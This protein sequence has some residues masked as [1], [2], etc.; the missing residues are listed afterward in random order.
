MKPIIGVVA[1]SYTDLTRSWYPNTQGVFHEHLDAVMASGAVPVVLPITDDGAI[2]SQLYAQIDGL[3][4][5][6]G[7]DIS[8]PLYGQRPHQPLDRV[9][10]VLDREEELLLKL[11]ITD[12]KPLFGICRGMQLINVAL[13][14]T[15]HQS[16]HTVYPSDINHNE[17][18]DSQ[19]LAAT[20]HNII[21]DR[22]SRLAELLSRPFMPVVSAHRQGLDEIGEGL[23]VT[24]RADDGVVEAIEGAGGH[25][26]LGVQTH[27]EFMIKE[28]P[29][30]GMLYRDFIDQC[31]QHGRRRRH[32]A[33]GAEPVQ[34]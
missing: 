2:V 29:I 16:V 22:Q 13:G 1:R 24:A 21:I 11:A 30:W 12:K 26:I 15:L 20:I 17:S 5:V 32:Q 27:P 14:G 7:G 8:P 4:L 33:A 34:V 19:N 23:R 6:G 18:M 28:E 25:Y 3:L 10:V 9:N 31:Q